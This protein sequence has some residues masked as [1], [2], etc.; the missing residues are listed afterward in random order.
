MFAEQ[1]VDFL[2]KNPVFWSR[3]VFCYDPPILDEKGAPLVFE[4]DFSKYQKVHDAFVDAGVKI[5]TCILHTGW[6]GVDQYDYSLCDKVLDALFASGKVKYFIPRIKCNVP[7]DWC[8]KYPEEVCVYYEGPR[9]PEEIRALVG[10]ERHDWLGYESPVGYYNANGWKDTRPNVGGVI[11]MQSF[12]SQQWLKDAGIALEKLIRHLE[13]GPYG[14]KILAYHIA[15]GTSGEAMPW[16]RISGRYGDYG[17]SNQKAFRQWAQKKYGSEKNMMVAWGD[18]TKEKDIVPPPAFRENK[19]GITP[20]QQQWGVDYDRFTT[21][22]NTDPMAYFGKIV[23]QLTGKAVGVFYGYLFHMP[24]VAYAGHLGWNKVLQSPYIDFFAAPKSYF[25]CGP[26]EPGGEMAPTVAI[27]HRKLWVDECDNRTHL[28]QGENLCNAKT[29]EET[30]TVH[31]RELCKNISHNSGLW[32]MDLGGNWFDDEG[33]LNNISRLMK[34]SSRIRTRKYESIAEILYVADENSLFFTPPERI[35]PMEDSLRNWQLSGAP[36]DTV[37]T[38]DLLRLPLDRIKLVIFSASIQYTADQ[39]AQLRKHLS[40][41]CTIVWQGTAPDR[42]V[43][44]P[45]ER[46]IFLPD[47]PITVAQARNV[48]ETAG[49]H[50]F[51][52]E[53]CTVYADNRILSFFPRVDMNFHVDLSG[54]KMVYN[55]TDDRS[56]GKVSTLDLSISAGSGMFFEWSKPE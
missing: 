39:I 47:L 49:V 33:I 22:I 54:E 10:T 32:Y 24:R 30:C 7:V 50:C 41:D 14:E 18:Y 9:E 37:F 55:I 43:I 31:T 4:S 16:G 15:Y 40:P 48:V 35:N 52:P 21:D 6:V 11:S 38:E 29:L 56:L 13:S 8:R 17:Y 42:S 53:E 1:A 25:R 27:N 5:H 36:I 46:D 19:S 34:V 20:Q 26:G 3:L 2:R 45:S 44:S 28:T 51:A 23:K 12:S